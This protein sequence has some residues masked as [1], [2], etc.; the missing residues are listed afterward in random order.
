MV[1]S[2]PNSPA[3]KAGLGYSDVIEGINGASVT[4]YVSG[5]RLHAAARRFRALAV[6]LTVVRVRHPD[7]ATVSLTRANVV[8]PPVE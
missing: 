6:D 4:R 8:L 5:E 2:I 1:D 7:P 3:A